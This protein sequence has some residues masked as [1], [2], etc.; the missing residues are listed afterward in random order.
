MN[1]LDNP[2]QASDLA[3]SLRKRVA[4]GFS[5]DNMV[6]GVLAAYQA[7]LSSKLNSH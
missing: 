7:A 5:L 6:E 2:Q 1:T 3:Q 4:E